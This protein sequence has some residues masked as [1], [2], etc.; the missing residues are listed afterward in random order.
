MEELDLMDELI[1]AIYQGNYDLNATDIRLILCI[2]YNNDYGKRNGV[3]LSL[4]TLTKEINYT[5]RQLQ[6]QLGKLIEMGVIGIVEDYST[7][8]RYGRWL[9]VNPV[10]EWEVKE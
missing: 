9:I 10:S 1:T 5:K 6:R 3:E 2:W 8:E 7:E 4:T